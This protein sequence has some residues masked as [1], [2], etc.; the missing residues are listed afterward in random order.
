MQTSRLIC[1]EVAQ[2]R[3]FLFSKRNVHIRIGN[4]DET[5][6][7][8]TIRIPGILQQGT[9]FDSDRFD[10]VNWAAFA[11]IDVSI[12][13]GTMP[14]IEFSPIYDYQT[15][16]LKAL[17]LHD[18]QGRV[19]R[20]P[21]ITL[22]I[23]MPDPHPMFSFCLYCRLTG[24]NRDGCAFMFLGNLLLP[25]CSWQ[26]A[27]PLRVRLSS[28][29]FERENCMFEWHRLLGDSGYVKGENRSCGGFVALGKDFY[30]ACMLLDLMG[31]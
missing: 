14:G 30:A 27:Q 3:D 1:A 12:E 4:L 8:P 21:P 25:F 13:S 15:T 17:L 23:V 9:C 19:L 5:D 26:T 6:H 28:L 31:K 11:A 2:E 22:D 20:L 18:P 24:K 10:I 29:P 16:E 7:I